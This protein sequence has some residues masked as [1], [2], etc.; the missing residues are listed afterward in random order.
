MVGT[1]GRKFPGI[2]AHFQ[3][4][5]T[6][7]YNG[8]DCSFTSY[9]ADDKVDPDAYK[10]AIEA[11]PCKGSVVVIFTP[12][13]THYPIALYAIERGH[14]VM[15]TKPATQLLSQH[16]DLVKKA[17]QNGVFVY[18]EHHKRFDPAY[19]DARHK[20]QTTLGEFNYFYSYSELLVPSNLEFDS[21]VRL[22][23]SAWSYS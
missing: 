21:V 7:V 6:S 2:R 4:N 5:I 18:V 23:R 14:H 1:N 19:A 20:A 22:H 10:T 15:L 11:L 9:P 13:P 16:L 8:L 17:R 12:D 3:K